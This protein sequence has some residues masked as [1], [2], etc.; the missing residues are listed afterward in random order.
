V[1]SIGEK[2]RVF[3]KSNGLGL[4]YMRCLLASNMRNNDFFKP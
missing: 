3:D 2:G 1:V 4:L